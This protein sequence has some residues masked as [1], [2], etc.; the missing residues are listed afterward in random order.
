MDMIDI[1]CNLTHDSFDKDRPEVI[2]AARAVG[3][4]QMVVTGASEDGSVKALELAR[5]WPGILSATAGVHP[6]LAA[7]FSADTA[8]VLAELHRDERVVAVG[9]CGLDYFRDFSPRPAQRRAFERQLELAVDCGKP[10]FLH[11]REAHEDFMAILKEF[12]SSLG[13][14]VVH[15]FT[16]TREAML[17]Y[18]ALDCH[19]GITGWICDE[20]R[21]HHLKDFVQEIPADRLMIETDAPY[22]KPRN[23]R[24]KVKSHRNEPQWLPWIAGTVAACRGVSPVRLAEETTA[25]ARAFFDL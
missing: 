8:S 6:H 15:C 2:E 25:T 10:V 11:Q 5:Q 23:L 20:R 19:I 18:L 9:E 14:L 17:D 24:P 22:L 3:V 12:R 21:G 7:D 16:D 13:A 1:G 4:T